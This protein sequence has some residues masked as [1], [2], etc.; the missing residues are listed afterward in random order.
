MK[1]GQVKRAEETQ[2]LARNQGTAPDETK[3]KREWPRLAVCEEKKRGAE[4]SI[5]RM[6]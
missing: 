4:R 3:A 5:L 1:A 2:D 6:K